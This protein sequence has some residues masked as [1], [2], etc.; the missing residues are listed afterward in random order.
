MK[1]KITGIVLGTIRHSDR[2]SVT[3]VYTRERGRMAFLTPAGSSRK[4]RQ[5]SARLQPLSV[6]EAEVSISA[7]RDLHMP[8]GVAPVKVWRTLYQDPMKVSVVMFLSEFLQRLLREAPPE[9]NMWDFIA[10]SIALFDLMADPSSLA[11]FH[12]AFLV[13]MMPLTGI[14]PD[15]DGYSPGM[16]FDM[17]AGVPVLPF[18]PLTA[19]GVRI[20]AEKTALLPKLIRINYANARHFRFNGRERTLLLDK[21]LRYYGCHFPGC[22]NLK[23]LE[24][25]KEIFD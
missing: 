16:E 24:I 22:D 7:T 6:F 9:P 1:E 17:K 14:K 4:S 21:I 2:H 3:S 20:D 25:L 5:T 13:G 8:T 15:L 10:D 23:S 11:N 19:R 12:I 18:S